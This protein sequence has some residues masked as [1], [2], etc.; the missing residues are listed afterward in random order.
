LYNP[1]GIF[2]EPSLV[3]NPADCSDGNCNEWTTVG[4]TN[5]LNGRVTQ[6]GIGQFSGLTDCTGC[7][8][9]W[10]IND[11]FAI[12][13]EIGH[14]LGLEH[15]FL[16]FQHMGDDSENERILLSNVTA[17][18]CNCTL[19]GDMICDTYSDPFAVGVGGSDAT[20]HNSLMF[21]EGED[22][23]ISVFDPPYLD[24]C[25][26]DY[27]NYSS[28]EETQIMTNVMSFH[29]LT[30]ILNDGVVQDF[31]ITTGQTDFIK[32]LN[33]DKPWKVTS[34]SVPLMSGQSID[35]PTVWNSDMAFSSDLIINDRL[36][37]K[38]ANIFF[39][40][41]VKIT[42]NPGGKLYL[43]NSHLDIYDGECIG[44]D[45]LWDGIKVQGSSSLTIISMENGSSISGIKEIAIEIDDAFT[46]LSMDN[47]CIIDATISNDVKTALDV[48]G[49]TIIWV[50]N[51]NGN[52]TNFVN[53]IVNIDANL[54]ILNSSQTVFEYGS[55]LLKGINTSFNSQTELRIP[56]QVENG[57]GLHY[58]SMYNSTISRLME[59][60]SMSNMTIIRENN[61]VEDSRLILGNVTDFD[62]GM[63]EF[64]DNN[65]FERI[66]ID[67]DLMINQN[68]NIIARNELSS[69]NSGVSV[70]KVNNFLT[71]D[72]N[73]FTEVSNRDVRIFNGFIAME[74]GNEQ[75]A[76]GNKFS[77]F[78][79]FEN[80]L[81]PAINYFYQNLPT[82]NPINSPQSIIRTEI[83][84][85]LLSKCDLPYPLPPL[86]LHCYD[87]EE[88][89]GETGVDCGGECRPCVTKDFNGL[90]D[91]EPAGGSCNDGIMNND[92]TGVDCGGSLCPPCFTT[93]NPCN[94][95]IQNNG[96]SGI[97]CGGTC[98]PC[99]VINIVTCNNGQWDIGENST[100]CGGI[101]PDCDSDNNYNEMDISISNSS[102]EFVTWLGQ[103]FGEDTFPPGD[104]IDV[105]EDLEELESLLDNGDSENLLDLIENSNSQNS[106]EIYNLLLSISPNVSDQVFHKL[107]EKSN[108][109]T[110]DQIGELIKR[111][112]A[113]LYD[114]YVREV[115]FSSDSFGNDKIEDI[116]SGH[117]NAKGSRVSITRRI[118]LKKEF[119]HYL[120]REK[121][122]LESESLTPR[123]SKIRALLAKKQ[124]ANK[125]YQIY[126][127]FISEGNFVLASAYINGFDSDEE[128]DPYFAQQLSS[129]QELNALMMNSIYAGNKV[130]NL[131][132][133]QITFLQNWAY[134]CFGYTTLKS[135]SILH[136]YGLVENYST[137]CNNYDA[138]N[139][140][141]VSSE[142]R[143]VNDYDFKLYPNPATNS[144][145]LVVR[146]FSEDNSM[147]FEIYNLV[148]QR[149]T[150]GKVLEANN[151]ISI[152]SFPQG[153][154]ILKIVDQ[155]NVIQA[156]NFVK[157]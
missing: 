50:S 76:S 150:K 90:A 68:N 93:N 151:T 43:N 75:L 112:P 97:D 67:N 72:C 46:L 10:S 135:R 26:Q 14:A 28:S 74:Q 79:N 98:V 58:F 122:L 35:L 11:P 86:P 15:T 13:H 131:S 94:D 129:F 121:I 16:N 85:N 53:G 92:E 88:N 144:L 101:C 84:S 107:F 55:M 149:L 2:F 125:K 143:D 4:L 106:T 154:Y 48:D 114:P 51:F 78:T 134:G 32:I 38:N 7:P 47:N 141:E 54:G 33:Q 105:Y 60:Q 34:N 63:N 102:T 140:R 44:S 117:S 25:G 116:L 20:F 109:F 132:L 52:Q 30:P 21:D 81:Q 36:T 123:W 61:F 148:G 157:I 6:F 27:L 120:I 80:N 126:E 49:G 57:N 91:I 99:S 39:Q 136:N 71:L 128:S 96:E 1:H 156:I 5:C 108:V 29:Y 66:I 152:N 19:T 83:P 56:V 142:N 104:D 59:I 12:S 155:K 145:N 65:T 95:G 8:S 103:N 113:S 17:C 146:N 42:I 18:D 31:N 127:S 73:D 137:D 119:M 89:N 77:S 69:T 62:I 124:D 138:L 40:K 22:E 3:A 64:L 139:F 110:N 153:S 147:N 37:I 23:I 41:N 9:F 111:N 45:D 82:Q 133:D 100:D 87:G 115:V 130:D 118:N 24:N 70:L